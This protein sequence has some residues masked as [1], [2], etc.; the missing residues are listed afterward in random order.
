MGHLCTHSH[1][2]G[3]GTAL[4]WSLT[5]RGRT[6]AAGLTLGTSTSAKGHRGPRSLLRPQGHPCWLVL[7]SMTLDVFSFS[8][9]KDKLLLE[10]RIHFCSFDVPSS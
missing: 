1:S 2:Q 10:N 7:E 8:I 3:P 4:I 9:I 6:P 5:R